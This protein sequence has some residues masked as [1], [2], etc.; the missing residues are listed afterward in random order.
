MLI[1]HPVTSRPLIFLQKEAALSHWN[2]AIAHLMAF[3]LNF[4]SCLFWVSTTPLPASS[5]L[6]MLA[7]APNGM[8][9][10]SAGL[11]A[12]SVAFLVSSLC[13]LDP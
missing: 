10:L 13:V 6:D 8:P 7:A 3:I 2:F 12:T 5:H 4:V 11:V 1:C 9:V